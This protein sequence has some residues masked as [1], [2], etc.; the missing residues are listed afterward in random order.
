MA[1]AGGVVATH[2]GR[3]VAVN[4]GSAAGE[5]AACV[6]AVGLGDRSDLIKLE[7]TG[8]RRT[9]SQVASSVTGSAP[10]PGGALWSGAAWWC[11]D[12]PQRLIVLSEAAGAERLSSRIGRLAL[13]HPA[14]ALRDRTDAWGAIAIVGAHAGDVLALIGVYGDAGDPRSVAP[15][16]RHTVGAADVLWLLQS[17]HCAL[18]VMPHGDAPAVWQA[19]HRAGR[20]LGICAVGQDAIARYSLLARPHP[21][22]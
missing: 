1:R 7:L 17:D 8:P 16:T 6:S 2:H 13:R 3:S 12:G 18:A 20:P 21:A 22:L 9:L 11:V 5:L 10:A 19:V 4:F 14:L 15:V